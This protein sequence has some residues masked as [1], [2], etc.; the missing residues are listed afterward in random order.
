MGGDGVDILAE[1]RAWLEVWGKPEHLGRAGSPADSSELGQCG[2]LSND[3]A[4][5]SLSGRC[6]S[7]CVLNHSVMSDSLRP[8]GLQPSRLLGPWGF[9]RSMPSSRGSSRPR[10]RSCISCIFCTGWCILYHCGLDITC[11]KLMH[12]VAHSRC[13]R[14]KTLESH[15]II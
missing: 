15:Q 7:M 6:M 8:C 5:T 11:S 2:V 1:G 10:D 9:P 12:W 3:E 13:S 4:V 14:F